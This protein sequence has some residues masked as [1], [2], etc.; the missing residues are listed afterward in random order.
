MEYPQRWQ[1]IDV[2][3][4]KSKIDPQSGQKSDETE[5]CGLGTNPEA[6]MNG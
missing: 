2:V 6:I 5:A 4:G 3:V 1:L